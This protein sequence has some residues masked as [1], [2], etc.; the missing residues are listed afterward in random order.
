MDLFSSLSYDILRIIFL[1]TDAETILPICLISSYFEEFSRLN[2]EVLLR[3]ILRRTT[4]FSVDDCDLRSLVKLSGLLC[5]HY[6]DFCKK[7]VQ[8]EEPEQYR[9]NISDYQP[10][11]K[12]KI[13]YDNMRFIIYGPELH[14]KNGILPIKYYAMDYSNNYQAL[15]SNF[16][17][18]PASDKCLKVKFNERDLCQSFFVSDLENIYS[19]CVDTV[20]VNKGMLKMF[21]FNTNVPQL[22][23]FGNPIMTRRDNLTGEDIKGRKRFIWFKLSPDFYQ[24]IIINND[25][26]KY[27]PFSNMELK[28]QPLLEVKQIVIWSGRAVLIYELYGAQITH[29]NYIHTICKQLTSPVEDYVTCSNYNWK[30]IKWNYMYCY[31]MGCDNLRNNFYGVKFLYD[32][33]TEKHPSFNKF[34]LEGFEVNVEISN[35]EVEVTMNDDKFTNVIDNI[36]I[37]ACSWLSRNY[38]QMGLNRFHDSYFP[39]PIDDFKMILSLSE[40]IT[41][42]NKYQYLTS[43]KIPVD[44]GEI[45]S[46][47]TLFVDKKNNIIPWTKLMN[48]EIKL[49]PLI[50]VFG[51]VV[52]Q[53]RCQLQM[54][55]KSAVVTEY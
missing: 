29:V 39:H 15:S 10:Y 50:H 13:G 26:K 21:N 37:Q 7:D 24:N 51:L 1:D 54:R 20:N 3:E 22:T 11:Y 5:V 17:D 36:Y 35:N 45:V 28:F 42:K 47:Q 32:Y 16:T 9:L 49:I 25:M 46:G 18:Q 2:L 48:R 38:L 19:L 52:N 55:L 34:E 23:G 27:A 30:N 53:G 31:D 6:T 4:N 33:G 44:D 41:P 14:S 12:I 40:P 43:Y 8:F